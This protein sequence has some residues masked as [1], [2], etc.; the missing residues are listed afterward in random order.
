M[1]IG[2][3]T[4]EYPPM[5]GGV[6]AYTRILAQHFAKC[7]HNVF[8]FTSI[9]AAESSPAIGLTNKVRRWGPITLRQIKQWAQA[10]KL[11]L[12]NLQFETAAYAMS[13]WIHFLADALRPIPLVT[14]FHDLFV[15]YLFPKAGGLR[16]W[17]M[18]HLAHTSAG[19]IV[20][21]QEDLM[22]VSGLTNA[23]LIPI[24]SNILTPIPPDFDPQPWREKAG[25]SNQDF[26]IGHFGFINRSKGVDILLEDIAAIRKKYNYP[27]KVVMVGGKTGSSDTSN[28]EYLREI[29]QL[30]ESLGLGSHVRWT[31]FIAD[32]DVS[33]FLT[34]CDVVALPFRDGASY[35]RGS[36]M[37]A[38]Y[39]GCVIITT[40]PNVPIPLFVDGEN[41]IL[42][43]AETLNINTPPYIHITHSLLKVYR[44]ADLREHLRQG[45][46]KL[47]RHFDWDNITQEY[48][49]YFRRILGA[50]S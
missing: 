41:M 3:V 47:A 25:A 17:I 5:Q 50:G 11:D 27:L 18:R 1:R 26:L 14:T 28:V 40:Q 23:T 6:G 24:G 15:P 12:I 16:H 33:A 7:E 49:A 34:A 22:R 29:E 32:E 42:A 2:I 48:L 39:H 10:E 30:I 21:N 8:V 13:P 31:D 44:D 36:L 20:T 9:A 46:K 35:R 19:V 45:A 38:I 43:Q 37:A 4:G